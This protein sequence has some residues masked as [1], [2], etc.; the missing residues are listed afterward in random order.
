MEVVHFHELGERP[1]AALQNKRW[2]ILVAENLPHATA[3]LMFSE[4][5]DVL[6]AVDHRGKLIEEGLWMRAVHLLLVDESNDALAL[7]QKTGITK[8]IASKKDDLSA[9][10]W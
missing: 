5:E 8:V 4:L 7:Q 2:L 9:H 3:A 6:V 10:L 1:R